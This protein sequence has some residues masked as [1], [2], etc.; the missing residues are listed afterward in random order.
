MRRREPSM[1]DTDINTHNAVPTIDGDEGAT[2]LGPDNVAIGVQNPG[3]PSTD[4]GSLPNL[5]WSFAA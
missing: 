4:S 3:A 2:V 1:T 5:K